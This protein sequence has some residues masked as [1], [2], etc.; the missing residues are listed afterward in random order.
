MPPPSTERPAL[1]RMTD[2]VRDLRRHVAQAE[3]I[4]LPAELGLVALGPGDGVLWVLSLISSGLLMAL[5]PNPWWGMAGLTLLF[6]GVLAARGRLR[7][8]LLRTRLAARQRGIAQQT[9]PGW[10][11]DVAHRRLHSVGLTPPYGEALDEVAAY[12]LAVHANAVHAQL[13]LQHARRGPIA[14]LI[15]WQLCGY[16][17]LGEGLTH[18]TAWPGQD[19]ATP[20]MALLTD[21][22]AL[23]DELA[24]RLD[25]R[26]SVRRNA[27]GTRADTPRP[28]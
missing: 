23:A 3:S 26:R 8:R 6:F 27:D 28:Q 15:R 2:D 20:V 24:E 14:T 9:G 21:I 5:A 11:L 7:R 25:M 12:S 19:P 16:G 18:D 17:L 4:Y 10:H 22:D 13:V 1:Q